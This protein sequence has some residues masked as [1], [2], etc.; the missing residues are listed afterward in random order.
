[1]LN[2]HPALLPAFGGKGMHGE[3][4][5][6]AVV[7]SGVRFSGPTVHFVNEEFDKARTEKDIQNNQP[8]ICDTQS[9]TAHSNKAVCSYTSCLRVSL[10]ND[11]AASGVPCGR[12]KI[13]AQR[14]VPVH[15]DDTPEVRP[16]AEEDLCPL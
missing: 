1:M 11:C 15:A 4:V 13:L 6:R 14:A 16:E 3:N 9:H 10:L 5:H 12:G 2:I 8:D 7:D